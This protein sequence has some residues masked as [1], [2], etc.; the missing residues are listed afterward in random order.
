[1]T[2]LQE[3]EILIF[4][5]CALLI[6]RR[7][8][9]RSTISHSCSEHHPLDIVR[10]I[11]QQV[12]LW[13]SEGEGNSEANKPTFSEKMKSCEIRYWLIVGLIRCERWTLFKLR[14][15]GAIWWLR[16][17]FISKF[18]IDSYLSL[19]V[20]RRHLLSKSINVLY[21]GLNFPPCLFCS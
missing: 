7:L 16:E 5:V 6:R 17:W 18:R 4:S 14:S 10:I 8:F 20:E 13:S 2:F 3:G 21:D 12:R 11:D 9:K 1:M 15:Q 19:Q